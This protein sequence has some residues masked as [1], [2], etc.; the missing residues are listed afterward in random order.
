MASVDLGKGGLKTSLERGSQSE[1]A[2]AQYNLRSCFERER[3]KK[4]KSHQGT[5][6]VK[7]PPSPWIYI[8]EHVCCGPLRYLQDRVDVKDAGS[9][10]KGWVGIPSHFPPHLASPR[11][12][13]S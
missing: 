2:D 4:K 7:A 1:Q 13:R 12:K 9:G 10:S 6:L 11:V 8:R 3:G 5:A